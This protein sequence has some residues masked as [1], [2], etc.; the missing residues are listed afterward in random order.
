MK[1]IEAIIQLHKLS[2]VVT[3]LHALPRFPGFTVLHAHGQG[4]GKGV[5]GVFAY[6]NK[7]GLLYNRCS[8]LLILCEAQ[9]STT[10]VETIRSAA[11]TGQ[12]GDGL[13]SIVD[14]DSIIRIGKPE[15]QA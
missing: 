6:D 5:G 14:V 12:A 15:G 2:K 1:R 7:E 11:H 8:V 10:I 4:H 9:S 3:A 13:I